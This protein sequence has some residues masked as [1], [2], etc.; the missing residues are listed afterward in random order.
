M[1]GFLSNKVSKSCLSCMWNIYWSS[2]SS[3]ANMKAIHW[4]IKVTYNFE[5]RLTKSQT[6]DDARRPPDARP[7]AWTSLF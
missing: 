4:R 5:K 7:P 1:D 3:L 6:S 2:A